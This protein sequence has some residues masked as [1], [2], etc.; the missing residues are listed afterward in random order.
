[1]LS[2]RDGAADCTLEPVAV[3][4]GRWSSVGGAAGAD[5][6]LPGL[7]RLGWAWVVPDAGPELVTSCML[8]R[9][10]CDEGVVLSVLHHCACCLVLQVVFQELVCC[11]LDRPD[12]VQPDLLECLSCLDTG[13]PGVCVPSA[14]GRG[15]MMY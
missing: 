4:D 15:C 13:K 10:V 3:T 2:D 5:Q 1:M 6:S 7:L 14:Q 12:V 9:E 8:C 11:C